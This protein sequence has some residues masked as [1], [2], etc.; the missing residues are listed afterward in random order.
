MFY[1]DGLSTHFTSTCPSEHSDLV[2]SP[3]RT[4]TFIFVF[5][6]L[7]ALIGLLVRKRLKLCVLYIW[8][9][10]PLGFPSQASW[11]VNIETWHVCH[12]SL[13]VNSFTLSGC[14][15]MAWLHWA[16]PLWKR[17]WEW[18]LGC[19]QPDLP[20]PVDTKTLSHCFCWWVPGVIGTEIIAGTFYGHF[21]HFINT[22]KTRAVCLFQL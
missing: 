6:S 7:S 16:R 4:E 3:Q 12:R 9:T 1:K 15:K 5:Y 22:N 18:T 14:T 13:S 8:H 20:S 19:R 21:L 10:P 17:I 2:R 11:L